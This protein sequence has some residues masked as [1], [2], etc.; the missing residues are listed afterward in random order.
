MSALEKWNAERKG[1]GVAPVHKKSEEESRERPSGPSRRQS[2]I[3][4]YD[5]EGQTFSGVAVDDPITHDPVSSLIEF[6]PRPIY[7]RIYSEP[8]ITMISSRYG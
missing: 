3:I 4:S 2:Q 6:E 1:E 8:G 5:S 7:S